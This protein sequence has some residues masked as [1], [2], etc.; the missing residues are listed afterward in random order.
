[1]YVVM[2]VYDNDPL[3]YLIKHKFLIQHQIFFL[4]LLNMFQLCDLQLLEQVNLVY[5]LFHQQYIFLLILML[6]I[7]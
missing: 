4:I 2:D 7:N 1:M 3:M 5:H 6:Y